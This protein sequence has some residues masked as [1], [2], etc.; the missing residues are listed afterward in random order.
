MTRAV[1]LFK[2]AP[3]SYL[4]K[5]FR[6]K[7]GHVNKTLRVVVAIGIATA[8]GASLLAFRLD[9]I[10]FRPLRPPLPGAKVEEPQPGDFFVRRNTLTVTVPREMTLG[11]F[12]RL[13]QL[14]QTRYELIDLLQVGGD[15]ER[16][17]LKRGQRVSVR[18][19]P[20]ERP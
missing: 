13:Y 15:P 7:R 20:P 17:V 11:E 14:Q 6:R 2:I 9:P 12:I 5:L 16:I 3:K 10:V 18:L 8:L 19:T 4:I 1:A